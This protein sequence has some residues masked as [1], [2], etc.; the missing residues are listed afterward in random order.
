MYDSTIRIAHPKSLPNM[1]PQLSQRLLT[2]ANMVSQ[3]SFVVDIG[4]DHGLLP[5]YLLC[6]GKSREAYAVD[7]SPKALQ[8][9]KKNISRFSIHHHCRAIQ[10]DGFVH[11]R[12][13]KP[14]TVCLAGMGGQ[15]MVS[16]LQRG[17][18]PKY[19]S[20]HPIHEI[21]VQPNKNAPLLRKKMSQWKWFLTSETIIK[22]R[23]LF[24]ITMKW[25][26]QPLDEDKVLSPQEM[27]LGSS[28]L[29]KETSQIYIEWLQHEKKYLLAVQKRA[30]VHFPSYHKQHL[31]WIEE[32]LHE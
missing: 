17:L 32:K 22:E 8:Q 2:I 11:L 24:Y 20:C 23:D 18:D 9:A 3:D 6:S 29:T 30:G 1:L 31:K 14:A 16:I 21:I 12:Y 7:K 5:V 10:S 19:Q 15:T 26:R 25:S 27:F 28:F 4:T 13:T